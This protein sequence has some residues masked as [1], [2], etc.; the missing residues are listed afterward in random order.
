MSIIHVPDNLAPIRLS[1]YWVRADF[2]SL[3][4]WERQSSVLEISLS[5]AKMRM[6]C[7]HVGKNV[8]QSGLQDNVDDFTEA[9]VVYLRSLNST[10]A[11]CHVSKQFNVYNKVK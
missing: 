5:S 11:F 9:A 1:P 6:S 2:S 4:G 7:E 8:S 10:S 3:F